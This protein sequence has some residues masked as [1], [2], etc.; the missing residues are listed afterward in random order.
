MSGELRRRVRRLE[1]DTGRPLPLIIV[2]KNE[3][4]PGLYDGIP[5]HHGEPLSPA[6]TEGK[7]LL[8]IEW[9]ETWPANYDEV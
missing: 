9:V 4:E 5:W 2:H 1:T 7:Q 6:D 8:V 3:G